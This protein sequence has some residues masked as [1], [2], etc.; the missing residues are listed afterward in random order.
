MRS[1]FES[2]DSVIVKSLQNSKLDVVCYN[3][4]LFEKY[5]SRSH[6][7]IEVQRRYGYPVQVNI[8]QLTLY[9]LTV[10]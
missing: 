1:M 2:G 10:S 4:W 8:G 6:L 3:R 9:V 5:L 7:L